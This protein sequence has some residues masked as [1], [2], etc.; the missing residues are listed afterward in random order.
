MVPIL[1]CTKRCK[2]DWLGNR[3]SL[4]FP[5]WQD[6]QWKKVENIGPKWPLYTKGIKRDTNA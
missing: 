1:E 2:G 4:C 3:R 5:I 6:M